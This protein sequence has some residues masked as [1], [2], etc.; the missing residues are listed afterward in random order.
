MNGLPSHWS[1][2]SWRAKAAWLVDARRAKDFSAACRM[3]A[4]MRAGTKKPA[5]KPAVEQLRWDLKY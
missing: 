3:L 1:G 4:G 2:M 5:P